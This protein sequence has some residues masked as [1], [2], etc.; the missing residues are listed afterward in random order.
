[1]WDTGIGIAEADL[2]RLFQP[3]TQLD[4]RLNRAYEGTGLGLAL[5]KRLAEAHGGR[6]SVE[7]TPGQGSR[8]SVT[9]PWVGPEERAA[10]PPSLAAP[11]LPPAAPHE[12]EATILL[13]EDNASNVAIIRD[14]L[15][16]QGYRLAVAGS[17]SEGLT[18]VREVRPALVL[19]DIQLPGMSGIDLIRHIRA[20]TNFGAIPIIALTA[21]AMPGD[22]E[23]CLAAGAD[24]YLAKPAPMPALLAAI[25]RLIGRP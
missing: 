13:V 4:S 21:L 16:T 7:S 12:I 18:L 19:M 14:M 11:V 15:E 1:M 6:V 5:V 8:F 3:F 2:T 23:R 22:R 24:E 20:D 17:G 25:A 9:L 10:E